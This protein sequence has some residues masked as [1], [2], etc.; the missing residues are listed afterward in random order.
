MNAIYTPPAIA[1][2]SPETWLP[3]QPDKHYIYAL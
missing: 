3:L 2:A 1:L